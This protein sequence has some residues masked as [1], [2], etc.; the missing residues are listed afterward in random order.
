VRMP[1]IGLLDNVTVSLVAVADCTV[2][3][4]PLLNTTVLLAAVVLKPEPLTRTVVAS[5]ARVV[6]VLNVTTGTTVATRTGV[7]LLVPLVVTTA[8]RFPAAGLFPVLNATVSCVAEAVCTMPSA[9]LLKVT[10]LFVATAA[11]KPAPLITMVLT[12]KARFAVLSVTPGT[13]LA[14]CMPVTPLTLPLDVTIAV[15]LPRAVGGVDSVTVSVV[16]VAEATVPAAP[17]LNWTVLTP[18]ASKP[19]P[20]ITKVV[21][22]PAKL[23]TLLVT[24]GL[25]VA[26]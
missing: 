24:T 18:V 4:A 11:S 26:T 22:L 20:L 7:P 19:K 25:T 8:V 2:P 23:A 9:P 3:M 10:T 17:L 1:A 14:T 15:R 12:L 21:A 6:V 5:G 13:T 16:A